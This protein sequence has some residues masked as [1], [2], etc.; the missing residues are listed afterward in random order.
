MHKI[1]I[2]LTSSATMT[3]PVETRIASDQPLDDIEIRSANTADD[4]AGNT[5]PCL[6]ETCALCLNIDY[7]CM[8]YARNVIRRDL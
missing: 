8:V 6:L 3:R 4:A 2:R 5:K 7:R 1:A